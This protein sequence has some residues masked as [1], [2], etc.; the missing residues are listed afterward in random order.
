MRRSVNTVGRSAN[1]VIT[2]ARANVQNDC[3]SKRYVIIDKTAS[4][5]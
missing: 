4:R 5:D 2:S 3:N 1:G